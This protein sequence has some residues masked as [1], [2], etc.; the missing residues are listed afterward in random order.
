MKNHLV[1]AGAFTILCISKKIFFLNDGCLQKKIA[2]TA[3]V[4]FKINKNN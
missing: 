3:G 1:N 4:F 2:F